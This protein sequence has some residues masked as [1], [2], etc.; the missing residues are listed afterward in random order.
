MG[1]DYSKD[2]IN[3]IDKIQDSRIK[4]IIR[5][6]LH[7]E[8]TTN[9]PDPNAKLTGFTLPGTSFQ[10]EQD[11]MDIYNNLQLYG[12]ESHK[13]IYE[14]ALEK[15]KL[16]VPKMH[17]ERRK[18]HIFWKHVNNEFNFI[19]L[20][21]CGQFSKMKISSLNTIFKRKLIKDNGLLAITVRKGS[22]IS[23]RTLKEVIFMAKYDKYKSGTRKKISAYNVRMS[24]IPRYINDIANKHNYSIDPTVIFSYQDKAR[25]NRASVMLLF[26]FK[27][28]NEV[29]DFDIW[30]ADL[31]DL[32]QYPVKV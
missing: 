28:Y 4:Q 1:V 20:D 23:D 6:Y 32:V 13:N 27:V 3:K 19:W 24:G 30:D 2:R 17:Y 8:I 31:V 16:L 7:S 22:E 12:V 9:Y 11:L 29:I 21:Y 14:K 25:N 10:L 15:Q 26:I 5:N 18:D